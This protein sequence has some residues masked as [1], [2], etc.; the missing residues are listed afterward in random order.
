M[1]GV[2]NLITPTSF[3]FLPIYILKFGERIL[4]RFFFNIT[5]KKI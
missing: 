1:T 5:I 3:V 4:E 2:I